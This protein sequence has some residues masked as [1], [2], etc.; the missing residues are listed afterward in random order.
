MVFS[1]PPIRSS[2][3]KHDLYLIPA[4]PCSLYTRWRSEFRTDELFQEI[5]YVLAEFAPKYLTLFQVSN[6]PE[7]ERKHSLIGWTGAILC[8]LLTNWWLKMGIMRKPWP[9]SLIPWS[10]WSRSTTTST[11]KISLNSLKTTW[12]FS[13]SSLKSIS[14]T[15][16][17]FLPLM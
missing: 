13:W 2:K 8:R 14:C 3:S 7:R 11:A 12:V 4:D 15:A 6:T 17:P 10:Y 9:S 1:K 5:L 16:I